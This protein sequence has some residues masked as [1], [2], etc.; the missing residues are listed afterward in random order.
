LDAVPDSLLMLKYRI[1]D[2]E[3]ERDLIRQRFDKFGINPSR[4]RFAGSMSSRDH[5]TSYCQVDIALDPFPYN[6]VTTTCEALW[7]G[8]PTLTLRMDRGMF[9][10]NGELIMKSVG[11]DEWVTGSVN[12]Y[13]ERARAFA[14]NPEWLATLRMSLRQALLSSPLCAAERFARNLEDAFHGMVRVS[15]SRESVN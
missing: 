8:V 9:G 14:A 7:M 5:L 3:S 2:H 4:L 6:G 12:E 1:F 15:T 13:R 11:L 10:H